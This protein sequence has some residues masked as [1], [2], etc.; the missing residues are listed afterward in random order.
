MVHHRWTKRS[1]QRIACWWRTNSKTKT[2]WRKLP[3]DL[4]ADSPRVALPTRARCGL[5]KTAFYRAL[6]EFVVFPSRDISPVFIENRVT[7][8]S[9]NVGSVTECSRDVLLRSAVQEKADSGADCIVMQPASARLFANCG[10][11]TR[12]AWTD[13]HHAASLYRFNSRKPG[14]SVGRRPCG[15][16]SVN[17]SAC[18]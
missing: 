15:R 4:W 13:C 18:N 10:A 6:S 5:Q 3:S 9:T 17:L 14:C 16:D 11:G 2:K 12:R 7:S 8:K 1:E